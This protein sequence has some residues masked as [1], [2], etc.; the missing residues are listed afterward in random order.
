MKF[1]AFKMIRQIP[2]KD[3]TWIWGE[4]ERLLLVVFLCVSHIFPWSV[5]I[6]CRMV[7]SSRGYCIDLWSFPVWRF[8]GERESSHPEKRPRIYQFTLRRS[9]I[10]PTDVMRI[11][12]RSMKHHAVGKMEV[13]LRSGIASL[14][15]VA[16]TGLWRRAQ[17]QVYIS[18]TSNL[19]LLLDPLWPLALW[20]PYLEPIQAAGSP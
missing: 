11:T 7:H 20:G 16:A 5:M 4:L 2:P 1:G 8:N 14:P 12:L 19:S 13:C 15:V 9:F 3:H 18:S 17:R 6:W 10:N